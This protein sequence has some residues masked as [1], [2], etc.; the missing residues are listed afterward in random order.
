MATIS[1]QN[2]DLPAVKGSVVITSPMTCQTEVTARPK[3]F[4][5]RLKYWLGYTP[6]VMIEATSEV[7]A[8]ARA[9]E[10]LHSSVILDSINLCSVGIIGTRDPYRP[11]HRNNDNN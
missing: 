5:G 8:R 4:C 3:V 1:K 11:R 6:V 10:V 2:W 9:L 7:Q